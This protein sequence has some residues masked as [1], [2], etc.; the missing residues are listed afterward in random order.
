MNDDLAHL[1]KAHDKAQYILDRILK[2]YSDQSYEID[3]LRA[4][5]AAAQPVLEGMVQQSES[6]ITR[7]A[8]H[9]EPLREA[10]SKALPLVHEALSEKRS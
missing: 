1:K 2:K 9:H 3:R 8:L 10:A 6:G 7:Y 4:A 5:L